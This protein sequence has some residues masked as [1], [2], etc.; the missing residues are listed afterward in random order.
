MSPDDISDLG[1]AL[2]LAR[3]AAAV[4]KLPGPDQ[5]LHLV[6]LGR[7]LRAG[8]LPDTAA[9]D[10]RE[11]IA[12]RG[13]VA[14]RNIGLAVTLARRWAKV[15]RLDVQDCESVAMEALVRGVNRY[16]PQKDR[17]RGNGSG[18]LSWAITHS[19]GRL[20]S[21][22]RRH[23]HVKLTADHYGA[24]EP[25][26]PEALDLRE[27]VRRRRGQTQA[28]EAVDRHGRSREANRS[29]RLLAARLDGPPDS[30]P[31]PWMATGCRRVCTTEVDD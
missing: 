30:R 15:Y 27:H 8:E 14:A 13:R 4:A 21:K 7:A 22:E 18:F 24:A 28:V 3:R 17:G 25:P 29:R 12:L 5:D 23:A 2:R 1:E 26:T 6:A 20:V 19:L 9:S 16:R 10:A 11:A 31:G